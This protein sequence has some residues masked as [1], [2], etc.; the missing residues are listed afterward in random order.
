MEIN[1]ILNWLFERLAGYREE[2]PSAGTKFEVNP[3]SWTQLK[4]SDETKF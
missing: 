1:N 3:E 4:G 2:R